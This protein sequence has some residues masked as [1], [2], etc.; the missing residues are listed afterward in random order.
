MHLVASVIGNP[1]GGDAGGV[2][3]LV[4][5]IPPGLGEGMCLFGI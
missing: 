4:N 2:T 3:G 1:S 5:S